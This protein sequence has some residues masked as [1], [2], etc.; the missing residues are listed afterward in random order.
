MES[1]TVKSMNSKKCRMQKLK[2]KK[3]YNALKEMQHA[4]KL[5]RDRYKEQKKITKNK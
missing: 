4:S 5:S 2:K 3:Q 1:L